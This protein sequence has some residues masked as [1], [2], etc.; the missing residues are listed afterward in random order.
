M[1]KDPTKAKVKYSYDIQVHPAIIENLKK[2]EEN[3][4]L[5]AALVQKIKEIFMIKFDEIDHKVEEYNQVYA[6]AFKQIINSIYFNDGKID[7]L[8]SYFSKFIKDVSVALTDKVI[9]EDS[10]G[11]SHA[12]NEI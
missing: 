4:K 9:G 3:L 5:E 12:D 10:V 8:T 2:V 1:Y 6:N 7:K 11:S